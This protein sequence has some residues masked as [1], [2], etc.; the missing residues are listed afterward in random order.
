MVVTVFDDSDTTNNNVVICFTQP[1]LE[2]P[3]CSTYQDLL[4]T[5]SRGLFDGLVRGHV[6]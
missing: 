5:E 1:T 4:S 2:E 3:E 6:A